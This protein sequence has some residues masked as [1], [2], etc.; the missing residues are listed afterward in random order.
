M[1]EVLR[2]GERILREAVK[3]RLGTEVLLCGLL[4]ERRRWEEVG[5][6]LVAAL[7]LVAADAP[8]DAASLQPDEPAPVRTVAELVA[9]LG[10]VAPNE[11]VFRIHSAENYPPTWE[12]EFNEN[13]EVINDAEKRALEAAGAERELSPWFE[14]CP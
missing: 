12:A 2:K 8:Q 11:I 7:Q 3:A 13:V 10:A 9:G 6:D 4:R 5:P 14:P 1:G